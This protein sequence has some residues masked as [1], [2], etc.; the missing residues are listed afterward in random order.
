MQF[1]NLKV[2]VC[3]LV[4]FQCL[5]MYKDRERYQNNRIVIKYQVIHKI[6]NI[7]QVRIVLKIYL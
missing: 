3:R 7:N 2:Q 4:H 5:K 1:K 6:N